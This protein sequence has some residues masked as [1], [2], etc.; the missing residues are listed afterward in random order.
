MHYSA[1]QR[2]A[3]EGKRGDLRALLRS[4][5]VGPELLL[6]YLPARCLA[7]RGGSVL[8]RCEPCE[9]AFAR[10]WRVPGRADGLEINHE[11]LTSS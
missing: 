4:L 1:M 11:L 8:G 5:P 7:P 6:R 9:R 2:R 10:V 3:R